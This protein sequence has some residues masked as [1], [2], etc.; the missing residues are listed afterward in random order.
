MSYQNWDKA[1][2]R[3]RLMSWA[4]LEDFLTTLDAIEKQGF[5]KVEGRRA[6]RDMLSGAVGSKGPFSR[7]ERFPE[8]VDWLALDTMDWTSKVTQ[9]FEAL[10]F[11]ENTAK[12]EQ[13]NGRAGPS[14]SS[15]RDDAS[16]SFSRDDALHSFYQVLRNMRRQIRDGEGVFD[17]DEFEAHYRLNWQATTRA[18]GSGGG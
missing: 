1:A 8:D 2:R 3:I 6:N 16:R 10:D 9:L 11:S 13:A 17:R 5:S 15:E 18:G 7:T 12:R 14:S 4:K